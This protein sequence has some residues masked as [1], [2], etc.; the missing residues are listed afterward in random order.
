MKEVKK[1]V[2]LSSVSKLAAFSTMDKENIEEKII[3]PDK[4]E[5]I[6]N[7]KILIEDAKPVPSKKILKASKIIGKK[8]VSVKNTSFRFID[9]EL[10]ENVQIYA[11]LKKTTITA[12]I[13]QL[14]EK[15]SNSKEFKETI[16]E[17][18]EKKNKG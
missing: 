8:G 5:K 18:I 17:Y 1:I 12:V 6:E 7:E 10:Y 4:I 15:F 2:P 16:S 13:M 11:T 14:L 9:P 3:N